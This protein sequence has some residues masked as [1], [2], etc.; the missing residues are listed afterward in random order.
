VVGA[1]PLEKDDN[2]EKIAL[3]EIRDELGVEGNIL[4]KMD[5]VMNEEKGQKIIVAPF[6]AM[7]ENENVRLNNEHTEYRWVNLGD[8]KKYDTIKN[9]EIIIKK[10]IKIWKNYS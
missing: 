3:R 4:A 1:A 2:M 9:T 7:I 8:L 6:L 5:S 10:L